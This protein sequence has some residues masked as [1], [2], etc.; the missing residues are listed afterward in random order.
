MRLEEYFSLL[1]EKV[2]N[3]NGPVEKVQ[4]LIETKFQYFTEH[5]PFLKLFLD[6]T[7]GGATDVPIVGIDQLF[8]FFA[9]LHLSFV[10]YPIWFWVTGASFPAT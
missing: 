5:K 8:L 1:K 7:L 6:T 9:L 2:S 3:S 10:L 4:A